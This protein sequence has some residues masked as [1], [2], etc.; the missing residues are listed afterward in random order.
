M[1]ASAYAVLKSR[2]LIGVSGADWLHFLQGLI[3]Q[4]VEGLKAGEA[5]FGALLT[6][7]GRL[8]YDLFVVARADGG[9]WLDVEAAHREALLQRLTM[10]RLRAKVD[11]ALDETPVS[12]LFSREAGVIPERPTEGLWTADPRLPDLGWRGYGAAAP[13]GVEV[14]DETVREAQKLRLGV[15]GP[16]DWLA[17]VSSPGWVSS[18]AC[19]S[20]PRRTSSWWMIFGQILK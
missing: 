12:V 6:P 13:A 19:A 1:S 9:A 15:P 17:G 5:R 14:V 20:S 16:A 11:L 8:L 10:Y 3:T 18:P 7:Q 2:A 4:D